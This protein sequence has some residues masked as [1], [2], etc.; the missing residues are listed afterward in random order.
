[1]SRGLI[2]ISTKGE[3][4]LPKIGI[5]GAGKKLASRIQSLSNMCAPTT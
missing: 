5:K 1:M 3:S 2:C 4:K